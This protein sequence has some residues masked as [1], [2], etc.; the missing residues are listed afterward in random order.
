MNAPSLK[1]HIRKELA[2]NTQLFL[3]DLEAM[4]EE[5]FGRSPGG[6]ARCP[7]DIVFE[8]AYIN[9]RLTTRL[10]G[11]DP[12]PFSPIPWTKAPAEFDTKDKAI[13]AVR[14]SAD[15]LLAEWDKLQESELMREI[16]TPGGMTNPLELGNL[17]ATHVLYHDAQ[18]NYIQTLAGDADMHW[19][20]DK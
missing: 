9:R 10:Q 18:L 3:D 11:G 5:M 14:E 1:D 20:M 2:E 16:Q 7:F 17:A 15:G 4:P 12:G 6:V 19:N 8:V 13:A